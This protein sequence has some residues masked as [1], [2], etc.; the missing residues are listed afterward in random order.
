MMPPAAARPSQSTSA[1]PT[2]RQHQT[3]KYASTAG[4]SRLLPGPSSRTPVPKAQAPAGYKR[5]PPAMAT[6]RPQN[7]FPMPSMA[8]SRQKPAFPAPSPLQRPRYLVT[9]S[10]S[11][12]V[13]T[14]PR[15]PQ[16]VWRTQ[17]A[18][19]TEPTVEEQD[20][21]YEE[22]TV[23]DDGLD[24]AQTVPQGHKEMSSGVTAALEA[25]LAAFREQMDEAPEEVEEE[26]APEAV[27]EELPFEEGQSMEDELPTGEFAEEVSI[28]EDGGDGGGTDAL[29]AELAAFREQMDEAPEEVEED[30]VPEAVHE[31]PPFEEGQSMEDELPTAEFEEE[32]TMAQDGGDDGGTDA[33]EAELAVLRE[34]MDEAPEDAEQEKEF[35]EEEEDLAEGEQVDEDIPRREDDLALEDVPEEQREAV[36]SNLKLKRMLSGKFTSSLKRRKLNDGTPQVEMRNDHPSKIDALKRLQLLSDVAAR[37]VIDSADVENVQELLDSKWKP[38]VKKGKSC[39]EDIYGKLISLQQEKCQ[40]S[41]AVDA[42]KAFVCKWKLDAAAEKLLR[43]M[44]HRDL[45]YVLRKYDGTMSLEDLKGEAAGETEVLPEEPG[46][47]AMDRRGRLELMDPFTTVLVVGDANL[48]F[49]LL[50][51]Q[52]REGLGHVGRVIA[53]TFETLEILRERYPEIDNTIKELEARNA[54]VLHNV[55]CTR[56]A[57]DPRFLGMARTFGVVYYNYP[58][59]GVVK[60][61]KDG[62]PFVRWRHENLMTLFFRAVMSFVEPGGMVKVCSNCNA[63]GVR[64]SDIFR[65]AIASEF[66]HVETVPFLE[67]ALRDYRRSYG[68]RRDKEKGKRPKKGETYAA[69]GAH[70]DMV[71]SFCYSPSGET[72]PKPH[73]R[74]PPTKQE[75]LESSEGCLEKLRGEEKANKVDEIHQLFLSYVQGVHVG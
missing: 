36:E 32:V 60:G 10:S 45:R 12:G 25:E 52:H 37:Y 58:H 13:P 5:L 18:R 51:A 19:R 70:R 14:R 35:A 30:C 15:L 17:P 38:R 28:P 64:Y 67:W 26:Y 41:T 59:A 46:P 6:S 74:L 55:D 3:A 47:F 62:H 48:T 40:I 49:S 42:V 50:L 34:Q 33:L 1:A 27:H 11:P 56:I 54:E 68:D 57:V 63:Q 61:F 65:G 22:V 2:A 43:G 20:Q 69:Q 31:E 73:I 16:T 66:A 7:S 72:P 23:E 75:L 4:Q 39:A 9:P 71:Y 8:A 21:Q 24:E 44:C 29:E 53:T